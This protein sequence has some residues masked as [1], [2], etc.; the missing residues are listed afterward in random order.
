MFQGAGDSFI[1]A[2]AYLMPSSLTLQQKVEKSCM[3]ASI[4]V[5]KLGTQSSYPTAQE[6]DI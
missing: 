5:T 2:L 3:I 1:G 6:V 4:S